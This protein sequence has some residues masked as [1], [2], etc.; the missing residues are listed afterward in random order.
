MKLVQHVRG[1]VQ[2]RVICAVLCI[3]MG[4]ML[5]FGIWRSDVELA[6]LGIAAGVGLLT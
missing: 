6:V 3:A 2:V 5:G 4:L 1:A